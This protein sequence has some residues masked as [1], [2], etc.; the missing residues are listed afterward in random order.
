MVLSEYLITK[1]SDLKDKVVLE[2]GAGTGL[3]GIV[4]G[5]LGEA[6]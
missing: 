6:I 1:S 5:K 3:A 4:A 2:L